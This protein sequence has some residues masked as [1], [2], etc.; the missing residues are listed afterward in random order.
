MAER[1]DWN[2]YLLDLAST[3][4][5]RSDCTRRQVG[6]VIV[7][8]DHRVV[9]TGYNG[10]PP[11]SAACGQ[12]GGCIRGRFTSEQIAPN[13]PY[14]GVPAVCNAIHAEENAIL[15][16]RRDLR[17]CDLYS[18]HKPCPNCARVIRGAM[19]RHVYWFEDD[20]SDSPGLQ[21]WVVGTVNLYPPAV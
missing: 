15:W 9:S 20:T 1:P 4:A 19:L 6:A 13:S 3:V 11:G 10:Y 8:A 17:E 12:P 18:T 2:T 14:V 5:T 21:K 16:A 7:D